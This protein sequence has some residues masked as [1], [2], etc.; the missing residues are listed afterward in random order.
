MPASPWKSGNAAPG[1]F[2]LLG[3]SRLFQTLWTLPSSCL[4]PWA[5]SLLWWS[6]LLRRAS[7]LCLPIA[8][9]SCAWFW[10]L[11]ISRTESLRR[12]DAVARGVQASPCHGA[13]PSSRAPSPSFAL[14]L[15]FAQDCCQ[16][17]SWLHPAQT[18]GLSVKSSPVGPPD[19]SVSSW[20]HSCSSASANGPVESRSTAGRGSPTPRETCAAA[21]APAAAVARKASQRRHASGAAEGRQR[22][23]D[24]H[25]R[26]ARPAT[27]RSMW[28]EI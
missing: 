22:R 15:S 5:L 2:G 7:G 8:A 10:G 3:R 16:S 6:A 13:C 11:A 4:G 26:Q 23:R 24:K 17:S 1:K 20:H 19:C 21:S 28:R 27:K 14:P 12:L 25:R 18:A 9:V